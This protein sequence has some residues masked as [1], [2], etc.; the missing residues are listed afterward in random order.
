MDW[1]E[2]DCYL[3][4]VS[5]PQRNATLN[6]FKFLRNVYLCHFSKPVADRAL[7]RLLRKRSVKSIVEIGVGQLQRTARLL[8]LALQQ[9]AVEDLKYAGIDLFEARDAAASGVGLK[10]AHKDLKPLVGKLQ[11]IPGDVF[12][13]L[14]R[15]ANSLTKT[16]LLIISAD[17]DADAL[18][19]AW[20][21][22][23]RM[24]HDSSQVFLQEPSAKQGETQ[25]RLLKR[26]E[27]EQ[28]ASTAARSMRRAA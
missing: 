22:V 24:L 21:Y 13:A 17:V 4:G 12:S 26:L 14:A 9:T 8:E 23:P 3:S 15:S 10:Q 2:T 20:F 16:D 5:P 25:F 1:A 6:A 7:Y 28:L 27:I 19:K 18:T 11:L